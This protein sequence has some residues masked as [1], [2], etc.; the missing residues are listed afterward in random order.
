VMN[1]LE[2]DMATAREKGLAL[3]VDGAT[4]QGAGAEYVDERT[5][6]DREE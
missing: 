3:S 2:E 1:E 6:E 4:G 5:K